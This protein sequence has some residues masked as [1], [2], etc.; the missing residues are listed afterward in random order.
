MCSPRVGAGRTGCSSPD[1]RKRRGH[2]AHR[3][4]LGM[5]VL[6]EP[7]L[8]ERCRHV[9][10]RR[11]RHAAPPAAR[12]ATP[13]TSRPRNTASRIGSSSS[14]F[15]SRAAKSANRGSSGELRPADRGAERHPELL[16]RAGD[17]DPAVGGGE[18]PETGRSRDGRS[19]DAAA[20]CSRARPPR[21]RRTSARGGPCRRARRRSRSRRRRGGRATA[22]PA[23]RSPTHSPPERSTSERPLF[24]GGPS[25]SPVRLIHPASPCIM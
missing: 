25:G 21:C 5:L 13:R 8:L 12:R 16:L 10:H 22:L 19:C 14:R 6:H 4:E 23:P 11:R 2:L 3:A 17:D 9:V 1:S 24:V 20:G 18:S 15:R 7:C